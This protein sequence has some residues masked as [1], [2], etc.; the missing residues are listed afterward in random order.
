MINLIT[1]SQRKQIRASIN[2]LILMR[3][4]F[5]LITTIIVTGSTIGLIYVSTIQTNASLEK[6]L[7]ESQARAAVFNDLRKEAEQ[8]QTSIQKAGKIMGEQV[9][10]SKLFFK[11]AQILPAGTTISSFSITEKSIS[12]SIQLTAPNNDQII[13]AKKSLEESDL[14]DSVSILNVA[15]RSEKDKG[16]TSTATIILQF[17]KKALAETISW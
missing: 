5:F 10:Y 15:N 4:V 8:L 3:Y 7:V 17:N 1:T 6:Q 13:A 16:E 9:H 12:N 11:L 2:N 14:I